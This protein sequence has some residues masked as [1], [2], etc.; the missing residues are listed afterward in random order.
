M[1]RLLACV[2]LGGGAVGGRVRVAW[3]GMREHERKQ[4][5]ACVR[6]RVEACVLTWLQ[7]CAHAPQASCLATCSHTHPTCGG[8]GH[9]FPCK[10]VASPPRDLRGFPT[11][12]GGPGQRA[13][14]RGVGILVY[15]IKKWRSGE[16]SGGHITATA[17]QP[18]FLPPSMCSASLRRAP[19]ARLGDAV[20]TKK[21]GLCFLEPGAPHTSQQPASS[22][23]GKRNSERLCR[24][25]K[26][27]QHP[28]WMGTLW[29]LFSQLLGVLVA[30]GSALG[31]TVSL[32]E[33]S[34]LIPCPLRGWRGNLHPLT[35]RHS[36][37]LSAPAECP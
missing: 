20:S 36:F 31:I 16:L 12:R 27:S 7:G 13:G 6:K 19:Q 1:T 35:S 37:V 32:R 28:W 26:V 4:G 10:A 14:G 34:H 2:L 15:K 11:P 17:G 24:G 3:G 23:W 21:L 9:L 8:W 33:S 18:C 30:S 22:S 5:H 29:F 25:L